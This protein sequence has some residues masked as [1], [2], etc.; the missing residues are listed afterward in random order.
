MVEKILAIYDYFLSESEAENSEGPLSVDPNK[1]VAKDFKFPSI[2]L[3]IKISPDAITGSSPISANLI[4]TTSI[5]PPNDRK[6][7]LILTR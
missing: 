7:T 5:I 6:I 1:S 3:N 4:Q 2:T